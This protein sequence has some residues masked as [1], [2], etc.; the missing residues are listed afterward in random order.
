MRCFLR[1]ILQNNFVQ[2]CA[3]EQV[4]VTCGCVNFQEGSYQAQSNLK[5]LMVL[6]DDCI[7]LSEAPPNMVA[8][9]LPKILNQVRMIWVNSEFYT[10]RERLTGI[11]KKVTRHLACQ[12]SLLSSL[13]EIVSFV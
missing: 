12:R 6:K 4:I 11:F 1:S 5:Y 8:P 7:D 10:S 2:D 3:A 9:I 13:V